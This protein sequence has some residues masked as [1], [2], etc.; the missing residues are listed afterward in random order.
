MIIMCVT[1]KVK[2]PFLDRDDDIRQQWPSQFQKQTDRGK[3]VIPD[4]RESHICTLS[5]STM[6]QSDIT[7]FYTVR[8]QLPTLNTLNSTLV[9]YLSFPGRVETMM[10]R[11]GQLV[12]C[13]K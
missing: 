7:Q 6:Q 2:P 12:Y 9:R 11:L 3:F 5:P 1:K 13:W 8:K 4:G 10:K